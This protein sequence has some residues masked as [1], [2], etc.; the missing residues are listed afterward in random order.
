M[1]KDRLIMA[2]TLSHTFSEQVDR[3]ADD[4]RA[5]A[6]KLVRARQCDQMG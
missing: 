5:L 4:D 6:R 3:H 1:K 2:K